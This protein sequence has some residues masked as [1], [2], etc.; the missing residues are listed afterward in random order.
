[1]DRLTISSHE[2]EVN[3]ANK[4]EMPLFTEQPSLSTQLLL[5]TVIV[6]YDFFESRMWLLCLTMLSAACIRAG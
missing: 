6:G 5:V 1:M 3:E 4:Q 2:I